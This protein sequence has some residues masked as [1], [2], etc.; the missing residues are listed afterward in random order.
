MLLT[1]A[2]TVAEQL[3]FSVCQEFLDGVGGAQPATVQNEPWIVLDRE[4]SPST[5][6]HR[7][8]DSLNKTNARGETKT[9]LPAMSPEL[10]SLFPSEGRRAA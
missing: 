1:E 2:I 8:I 5:N 9:R 10:R 7:I 3:G 6:L 4:Q